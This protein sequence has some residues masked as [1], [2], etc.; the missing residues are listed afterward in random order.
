MGDPVFDQLLASGNYLVDNTTFQQTTARA[1][2]AAL[3]DRVA[4][5]VV[6]L[7]HSNGGAGKERFPDV[8][9]CFWIFFF[10]F[11]AS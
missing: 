2:M 8:S 9:F 4:R 6:L 3:V 10:H 7:G 5:P 1:A 11:V